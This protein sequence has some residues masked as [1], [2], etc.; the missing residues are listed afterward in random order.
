MRGWMAGLLLLPLSAS[1]QVFSG[2]STGAVGNISVDLDL[3]AFDLSDTTTSRTLSDCAAPCPVS[4]DATATMVAGKEITWLTF[5]WDFGDSNAGTI[6]RGGINRSLNTSGFGPVA[7]HPYEPLDAEYDDDCGAGAS[8]CAV[9]TGSITVYAVVS[10]VLEST[11]LTFTVQVE[12]PSTTWA[13]AAT[14]CYGATSTGCP[15]GADYLG[16]TPSFSTCQSAATQVLFQR[17]GTYT[18]SSGQTVGNNKCRWG[19]YHTGADPIIDVTATSGSALDPN[20]T[21]GGHRVVGIDFDGPGT[22]STD[23]A[24]G[25]KC[26]LVYDADIRVSGAG[27]EFNNLLEA[28]DST[29]ETPDNVQLVFYKVR[30]AVNGIS[31]GGAASAFFC[32]CQRSAF[33]AGQIAGIQGSVEH[34]IRNAS[35]K[36]NVYDANLFANEALNKDLLDLRADGDGDPVS[37]Y[38]V[39]SRNQFS[40]DDTLALKIGETNSSC[41]TGS[42]FIRYVW[43]VENTFDIEANTPNLP[44]QTQVCGAAGTPGYT[45]HIVVALNYW[46]ESNKTKAASDGF[47]I[48]DQ[49]GSGGSG[50]KDGYRVLHNQGIWNGSTTLTSSPTLIEFS[51]TTDALCANN[52]FSLKMTGTPNICGGVTNTTNFEQSQSSPSDV[53]SVTAGYPTGYPVDLDDLKINS[54]DTNQHSAGTANLE[55]PIVRDVFGN[56]CPNGSAEI[57]VHCI[58]D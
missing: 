5:I 44:M 22:G 30:A 3:H 50:T 38:A 13:G 18:M 56:A 25:G 15:S 32:T 11:A 55:P 16:A 57:G 41:T 37:E 39:V 48:V 58:A 9:F 19:A 20:A 26:L 12:K 35:F 36:W 31:G 29:P 42:A 28:G 43:V 33:V 7:F 54:S 46:N 14:D 47:R 10:G 21:C 4:F 49:V 51:S 27:N 2:V 34:N 24:A 53:W 40:P 23:F 17:G 45:D 1:A 8:T 6:A 52:A